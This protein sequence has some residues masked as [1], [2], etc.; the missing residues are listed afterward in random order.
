[1]AHRSGHSAAETH[2]GETAV[3]ELLLLVV[4]PASVLREGRG[5]GWL[6]RGMVEWSSGGAVD[7]AMVGREGG[8]MVRWQG[9]ASSPYYSS[10]VTN[11]THQCC[12]Q[13]R[14]HREGHPPH[15]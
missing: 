15:K 12:P 14:S 9:A 2:H 3:V 11:S 5:G 10:T 4:H 7:G 6:G 13:A 8:G 1:M